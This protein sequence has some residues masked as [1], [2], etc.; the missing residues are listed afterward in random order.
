MKTYRTIWYILISVFI[1]SSCVSKRKF[2]ESE[3]Q[4]LRFSK[5]NEMQSQ[6]I[7]SMVAD[8]EHMKQELLFNNAKKDQLIS[9]LQSNVNQLRT[10]VQEKDQS[11]DQKTFSFSF[12]RQQLER[13]LEAVKVDKTILQNRISSLEAKI[14]TLDEEREKLNQ[15]LLNSLFEGKQQKNSSDQYAIQVSRLTGE[16]QQLK[17]ELQERDAAIERLSKNIELLKGEQG[18]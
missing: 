13:D 5:E 9:Q 10:N 8:Y 15:Q 6:R 14:V 7:N 3:D 11:I 4:V 12:E 17:K 1:L 18:R 2:L 16:V